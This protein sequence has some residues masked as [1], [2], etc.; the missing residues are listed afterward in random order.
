M[1][2]GRIR[3]ATPEDLLGFYETLKSRI[4]PIADAKDR[5]RRFEEDGLILVRT[6]DLKIWFNDHLP[7]EIAPFPRWSG[8]GIADRST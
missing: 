6:A 8:L 4:H 5:Q 2:A 3:Q 7:Q 1:V